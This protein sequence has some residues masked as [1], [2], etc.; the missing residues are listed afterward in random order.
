M[1]HRT[2]RVI[3][4]GVA[5]I[6]IVAC[7]VYVGVL[8][9]NQ[10][11]T[12][13]H[14]GLTPSVATFAWHSNPG[15]FCGGVSKLVSQPRQDSFIVSLVVNSAPTAAA[16]AAAKSYYDNPTTANLSRIVAAYSCKGQS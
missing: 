5:I 2:T 15:L 6:V 3:P 13:A 16:H 1:K 14:F 10:Q 8:T 9:V 7:V 4:L 11:A 12:K